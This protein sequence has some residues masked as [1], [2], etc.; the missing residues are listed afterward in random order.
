LRF[1]EIFIFIK[2]GKVINIFK[3]LQHD[4]KIE[5]DKITNQKEI[6]KK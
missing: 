2:I 4:N 3:Y 1:S 5:E 6:G